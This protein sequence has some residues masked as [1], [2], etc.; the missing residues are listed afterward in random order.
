MQPSSIRGSGTVRLEIEGRTGVARCEGSICFANRHD[1]GALHEALPRVTSLRL[2]LGGVERL[3]S[4]AL[5]LIV[6]LA[7]KCEEHRVT[8]SIDPVSDSILR[9]FVIA[10]LQ[11]RVAIPGLRGH[12]E[13]LERYS[14]RRDTL[15]PATPP[16][17]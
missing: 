8:L 4:A 17:Q 3:E 10:R 9:L 15:L 5:G 11:E 14:C 1:F 6:L 13:L 12:E 7:E 2:D 16:R